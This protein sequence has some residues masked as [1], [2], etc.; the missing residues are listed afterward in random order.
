MKKLSLILIVLITAFGIFKFIN[1]TQK[2]QTKEEMYNSFSEKVNNISSYECIADV[3]VIGNKSPSN[4]KFKHTYKSPS[5]Y[6]IETLEPEELKGN[7]VEYVDSKINLKS[8]TGDEV[9]LPNQGE[10]SKNLFL[11]DFINNYK[12]AKNLEISE[13]EENIILE[14]K[15][16]NKSEYF[17]TQIL[18]VNKKQLIPQKMIILDNKEQKRFEV[19]YSNFRFNK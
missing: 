18:Y 17:E 14:I 16:N 3:L 10:I 11:G 7:I 13:D 9:E 19:S 4:Y 12:E 8:I 6:K 5:T 15:I 1:I 2:P